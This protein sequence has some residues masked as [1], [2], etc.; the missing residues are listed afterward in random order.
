MGAL[1]ILF[2]LW[3][4]TEKH[5]EMDILPIFQTFP[6]PS[7]FSHLIKSG[8]RKFRG[9][10]WISLKLS[11][12]STDKNCIRAPLLCFFRY[13]Y[14]FNSTN[15]VLNSWRGYFCRFLNY[16]RSVIWDFI[17]NMTCKQHSNFIFLVTEILALKLYTCM[18]YDLCWNIALKAK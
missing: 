8:T 11:F 12:L 2:V 9:E 17:K 15:D 7:P 16:L 5:M 1:L 6:W 4:F 14:R 18:A 10:S 13:Y 3:I